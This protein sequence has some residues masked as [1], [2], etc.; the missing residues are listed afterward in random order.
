MQDLACPY[1]LSEFS[2]EERNRA[3]LDEDEEFAFLTRKKAELEMGVFGV[4]GFESLD[5]VD[6]DTDADVERP[7]LG[8]KS[9]D[10]S[11]RPI[12]GGKSVDASG[13]ICAAPKVEEGQKK[14]AKKHKR[15]KRRVSFD[16][17]FVPEP[18]EEIEDSGVYGKPK[19]K[20]RG[21]GRKPVN[22]S[23]SGKI[24]KMPVVKEEENAEDGDGEFVPLGEEKPKK[25]QSLLT[26]GKFGKV[27]KNLGGGKLAVKGNINLSFQK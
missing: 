19:R 15:R 16:G 20:P 7:V 12:Y 22:T 11:G 2:I 26:A 3:G 25:R 21:G 14:V 6:A 13:N 8:G 1:V 10:V 23:T 18:L 5:F 9:I 24:V 27:T 4:S 17:C